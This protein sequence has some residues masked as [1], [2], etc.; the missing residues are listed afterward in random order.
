M[1]KR[2]L[3]AAAAALSAALSM[4]ISASAVAAS[5]PFSGSLVFFISDEVQIGI[6]GNG[7][8]TVSGS[9]GGSQITRVGIASGV[10]NTQGF[11]VPV[12]DP[13]ASPVNGLQI[14]AHNASG[15]LATGAPSPMPMLGR[16]TVCLFSRCDG[17]PPAN[18][19]VPVSVV[20]AGGSATATGTVNVTVVGAPW[21]AGTASVPTT[22]G[23]ATQMGFAHGPASASDTAAN[24]SGVQSFVTP[25]FISTD[26]AVAPAIPAFGILTL[27]FIPEPGTL[28]LVA[29]GLTGMAISRRRRGHS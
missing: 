6:A 9:G 13:A 24:V 4:G 16:V 8:A 26:L 3:F 14:T 1:K 19:T 5:L 10:F 28:L 20:G 27:H 7:I 15:D 2:A 29:V 23:F 18:V 25:I 22:F 17:A 21:T 11:S 12:T